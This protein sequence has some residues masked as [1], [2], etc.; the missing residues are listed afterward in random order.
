MK[1][2]KIV[3]QTNFY[4]M[5]INT[6]AAK[7]SLEELEQAVEQTTEDTTA[8]PTTEAKPEDE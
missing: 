4:N 8:E 5:G 6:E 3:N 2:M 1:K 7:G